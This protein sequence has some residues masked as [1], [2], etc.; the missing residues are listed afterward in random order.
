M[1]TGT[2]TA[3]GT[4]A[5]PR[6]ITT[7]VA[8][9]GVLTDGTTTDGRG[10]IEHRVDNGVVTYHRPDAHFNGW[11]VKVTSTLPTVMVTWPSSSIT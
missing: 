1:A 8:T 11:G 4:T 3:A 6:P 5:P 9:T 7:A 2:T 10:G